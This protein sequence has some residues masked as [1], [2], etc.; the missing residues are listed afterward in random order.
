V[1][2]FQSVIPGE[3][4]SITLLKMGYKTRYETPI[5]TNTIQNK[6]QTRVQ[7]Q[8][9]LSD[10]SSS[11]LVPALDATTFGAFNARTLLIPVFNAGTSSAGRVQD[12]PNCTGS[13]VV[14]EF[15]T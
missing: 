3:R 5:I 10:L 9:T 6:V 13:R 1:H 15:C 4:N 7:A 8:L 14:R 2:R 11:S 12:S